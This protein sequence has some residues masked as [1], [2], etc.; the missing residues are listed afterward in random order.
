MLRLLT[1]VTLLWMAMAPAECLAC[2]VPVFR[3]ALERWDRD[4]YQ[5]IIVKDG[6]FTEEEIALAQALKANTGFR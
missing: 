1:S 6:V 3:Y 5:I 4:L 2:S